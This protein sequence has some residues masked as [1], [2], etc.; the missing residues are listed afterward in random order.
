MHTHTAKHTHKLIHEIVKISD[1]HIHI[2][3]EYCAPWLKWIIRCRGGSWCPA[4]GRISQKSLPVSGTKLNDT[5]TSTKTDQN[6]D[7][8]YRGL[9]APRKRQ[10]MPKKISGV[11]CER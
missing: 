10:P 4:L 7:V 11:L 3:G 2:S 9:C 5:A 1:A 6:Y 8:P